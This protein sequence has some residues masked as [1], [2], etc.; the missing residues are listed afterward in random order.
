MSE[1]CYNFEARVTEIKHGYVFANSE[2][3]ARQLIKTCKWT[4]AE[5]YPGAIEV[6]DIPTLMEDK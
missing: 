1:K 6:E 5:T 3:E 4:E 2:E